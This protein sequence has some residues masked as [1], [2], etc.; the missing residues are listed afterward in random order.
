MVE[1]RC[2]LRLMRGGIH[3]R[4]L[5]TGSYLPAPAAKLGRT[6]LSG[7]RRL[8]RRRRCLVGRLKSH[9]VRRNLMAKLVRKCRELTHQSVSTGSSLRLSQL[10][11]LCSDMRKM[12]G[13]PVFQW[14]RSPEDTPLAHE[15]ELRYT[16]IAI[17]L[18]ATPLH[19]TLDES[20]HWNCPGH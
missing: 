19:I 13:C 9:T 8:P 6:T 14:C 20:R 4:V 16:Y 10:L 1:P 17:A 5:Y 15:W 2:I 12:V 11:A 18:D 3:T 7:T